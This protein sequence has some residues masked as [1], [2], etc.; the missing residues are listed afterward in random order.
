MLRRLL[1]AALLTLAFG[2]A[3][4]G[5][6]AAGDCVTPDPMTGICPIDAVDPGTPGEPPSGGQSTFTG[7]AME[8]MTPQPPAPPPSESQP[9]IAWYQEVCYVAGI[10]VSRAEPV[11]A[12]MLPAEADPRILAQQAINMLV[13]HA[14][15]IATAPP[16]GSP[17]T[18][19]GLPI[20]MWSER[21]PDTTGPISAT[22][23]AGAV[24]VTAT[25]RVIEIVWDM[26]DGSIRTCGLG[27]PYPVGG[28]DQPSP[29]CG[30]TYE[31]ASTNHVAGAGPWPLTATS[32]WEITWSGG[33][34]TGAETL[35]LTSTGAIMI[36]ELYVLNGD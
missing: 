10:E 22:A 20:W 24:S 26:G 1:F 29:D 12:A 28:T 34:M 19:V 30:Y 36:R 16:Q 17:G 14:P 2:V 7:C 13:M 11:W 9:G 3:P 32:T 31:M 5:M 25:G 27:T 18:V 6:A 8:Y 21:S 35:E 15:A 23:T 33:G 4:A